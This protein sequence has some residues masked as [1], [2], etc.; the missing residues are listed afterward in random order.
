MNANLLI[1][2]LGGNRFVAMSGAKNFVLDKA[3]GFVAFKVGRNAAKVTHV[4]ITL[5]ALDLY[6][7]EFLNIRGMNPIKTIAEASN[8]YCDRLQAEFTAATGLET[9]L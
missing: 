6:D 1:N 5:N 4:R 8:V 3:A 7:M 2:Q 9:R